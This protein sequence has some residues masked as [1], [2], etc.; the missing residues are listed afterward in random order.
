MMAR[1]DRPSYSETD[2]TLARALG[3]LSIGLGLVDFLARRGVSR[4]TGVGNQSLVGLYGLRE[5]GTGIGLLVA[6][7]PMLWV[8]ARVGG[9]A[10]DMGTLASGVTARNPRRNGALTGLLMVVGVTALDLALA[11]RLHGIAE[12]E[13]HSGS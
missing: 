10:L 13:A 1:R 12:R 9:D 8:W 11:G 5:I 7:D 3:V 6:R 2:L 4:T